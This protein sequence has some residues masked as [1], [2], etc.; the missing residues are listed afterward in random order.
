MK[1]AP[2][3]IGSARVLYYSPIDQRHRATGTCR[4]T[5]GGVLP[6]PSGGLAICQ[7][8]E[9]GGFSL[10]RCDSDWTEVT[11]T[12]HPTLEEAMHQAE[13]EYE[14]VSQTWQRQEG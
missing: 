3:E 4:H 2:T 7:Y 6:G 1:S 10:L 8:E 14:G 13:F 11:D 9:D 12:W 5:V